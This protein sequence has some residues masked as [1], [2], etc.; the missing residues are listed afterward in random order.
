MTSAAQADC[1]AAP[2]QTA[3]LKA[4]IEQVRAAPD[5]RA[6]QRISLEMWDVWDDAPNEQAQALLN[7]GMMRRENQDFVGALAAFEKLIDYCPD[8]AEGYN[9]RAFVLFIQ[10]NYEPALADL[11]RAIERSPMH[12]AAIAGKALTLIGLRRDAE[13]QIVLREA[14]ALNP[15]LKERRFLTEP[16]PLPKTDL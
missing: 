9:Q 3:R 15:W 1:P 12:I 2:D 16:A 10:Q 11:D 5:E 14:L 6:A 8:Y 4:L 13:A 7:D